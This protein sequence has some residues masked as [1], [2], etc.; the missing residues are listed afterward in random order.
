V[1]MSGGIRLVGTAELSRLDA[2]PDYRRA[3]RLLRLAR[4]IV[5]G[6]DGAGAVSWMGHRPSTPDSLPVICRSPRYR[7]AYFAFGHGHLG[8][9]LAAASGR[10]IA[11]LIAGREPPLAM[12]AFHVSRYRTFRAQA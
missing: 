8:L 9:T 1:Q 12:D 3:E 5:P 4:H 2:P 6:L 10:V 11:D 7:N